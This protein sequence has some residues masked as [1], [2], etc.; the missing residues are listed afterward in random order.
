[1]NARAV[2]ALLAGFGAALL[3]QSCATSAG[4]VCLGEAE[5]AQRVRDRIENEL[6]LRGSD[7]VADFVRE[8][9]WR[10][11]E[12]A[13]IADEAPWRFY[14]VRDRS[15]NAFSIGD[16]R[17]YVTEGAILASASDAEFAGVI[18]H[19]MGHQVAGHFCPQSQ[20]RGDSAAG[21][22]P[23]G[24]ATQLGS[25]RQGMDP[26]KER[27]AD[28]AAIRILR[29]AGF[30]PAVRSLALGRSP[31]GANGRTATGP[32]AAQGREAT[33]GRRPSA[34]V[35]AQQALLAER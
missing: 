29:D 16:G 8:F 26:A 7:A 31:A 34:L 23:Q 33:P 6:P 3:A 10:L 15:V 21:H 11:A 14:V 13:R 24:A 22:R 19:E 25:L 20:G 2:A 35:R 18:A 32:L 4:A 12:R 17:I 9:G 30:D 27:E 5:K 28:A 1:M